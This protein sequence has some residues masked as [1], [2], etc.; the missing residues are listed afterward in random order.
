M[1]EPKVKFIVNNFRAVAQ[2]EIALD[3]ISVLAGE[4]GCGKSS[5]SKLVYYAIFHLKKYD[6]I[7]YKVMSSPK[8]K[9]SDALTDLYNELNV[10]ES[11]IID[12]TYA[13]KEVEDYYFN[14]EYFDL[15]SENSAKYHYTERTKRI[16]YE[17]ILNEVI[18]IEN[19]TQRIL[20]LKT[21]INDIEN[22]KHK[23]VSEIFIFLNEIRT[24]INANIKKILVTKPNM[25]LYWKLE[26]IFKQ[27]ISIENFE[28]IEFEGKLINNTQNRIYS[29]QSI[30]NVS[31][32]DTP[33]LMG[34]QQGYPYKKN[35]E[36]EHW[37]YLNNTIRN[38]VNNCLSISNVYSNIQDVLNG[39]VE[40]KYRDSN[41]NFTYKRKDGKEID[42]LNCATGLK[43]FAILQLLYQQNY[44]NDKTLLIIDEPEAHLHPQWIVEYARLIVLLHKKLGVKFLIASHHPQMISSIKYIAEKEVVDERVNFY[45][46]EKA[47]E[48][49]YNFKNYGTDIEPIFAS[50]NI[51]FDKMDQ[52]AATE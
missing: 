22:I 11:Y 44:L 23:S 47:T 1:P 29:L 48:F 26:S 14:A 28:I 5:I 38:E 15:L 52:Y 20:N 35:N 39:T 41:N 12:L 4:N 13:D 34:K 31:Y 45:L 37:T 17:S 3:G 30:E 7:L 2:A 43:S 21:R 24:N 16:L 40:F 49:T 50:F 8:R 36:N 18:N 32:L 10:N 6:G 42:L 19:I 46:G 33:M 51:A 9:L 25:L 27:N